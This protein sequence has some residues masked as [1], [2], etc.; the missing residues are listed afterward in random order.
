MNLPPL[1][2][3]DL[4]TLAFV[5]GLG[6]VLQ[7]LALYGQYRS[8][9]S[10]AGLGSWALGSLALV[11]AFVANALRAVPALSPYGIVAN[12]VLFMVGAALNYVG[13][14]KFFDR[15]PPGAGLGVFMGGALATAAVLTFTG[16]DPSGRRVLL[17]AGIGILS[18]LTLRALR[19]NR[20]PSIAP[21]VDFLS[22]VFG[23]HGAF[24][25][26]RAATPFLGLPANGLFMTTLLP[27][28]TYLAAIAGSILWSFGFIILVNQRLNAESREAGEHLQE[29]NRFLSEVIENNGA[30]IYVKDLEGRYELVNSKWEE[31]TGRS[32]RDALGRTDEEIF[33]GGAGERFR[34]VDEEVMR[35]GKLVEA[36]ESLATGNGQRYFLSTKFP[37]WTAG[38]AVRGLCGMSTDITGSKLDAM[39]IQELATQLGL[40][41]DYAQASARTDALTRLAN[42]GQFDEVLHAEFQRLKRSGSPLSLILLD[43][44]HFKL[45]NDR[46]GHPAGDECLR[47]LARALKAAV[48][49][50]SDLPARYG[51]EEFAVVL[52]D[53]GPKGTQALAERIR[54]AVED[55]A[56]PHEGNSASAH[57]TVSLGTATRA[58]SA[59]HSPDKLLMLADEALYR[60]KQGGRNRIET[61]LGD[62]GPDEGHPDL[63]R[64][65]WRDAAESGN[66]TIDAQHRA[67]FDDANSLL[68]A[69]VAGLPREVC[70]PLMERLLGD[71]AGH[72]RHE[73]GLLRAAG[74]PQA[75][76]HAACHAGLLARARALVADYER[77][78]LQ[79]GELFGFVADEVVSQHMFRED[80]KYFPYM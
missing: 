76:A 20:A 40:E 9:A 66:A 14:L 37:L 30:L 61:A 55:L 72:F 65:V 42:R 29:V 5:L 58:G 4:H 23:V 43:V 18:L 46:Y 60:A 78:A 74:Y 63:V 51:G 7:V 79:V 27:I 62:S 19:E 70:L 17:S 1:P 68:S 48:G 3:L 56:I 64:L 33:P 71:L 15:K 35:G 49:R 24:F 77:D 8:N 59:L 31:V 26:F 28:T 21:S 16:A 80:R 12:N 54:R 41:R 13:V 52:P 38:K 45:Y 10:R 11:L 25:V 36:E 50:P 34:R 73:E 6:S 2:P 39:R 44:D 69:V 32:R 22:V 67:L 57:V 53:T 47:R 75:E